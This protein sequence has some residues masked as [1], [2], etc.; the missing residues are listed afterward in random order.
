MLLETLDLSTQPPREGGN[1][2]LLY[3]RL[4]SIVPPPSTLYTTVNLADI[5]NIA[6]E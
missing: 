5:G 3:S 4:P 1:L 2:G 6:S